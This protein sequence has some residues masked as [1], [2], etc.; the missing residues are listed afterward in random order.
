LEEEDGGEAES[1]SLSWAAEW[2][3]EGRGTRGASSSSSSTAVGWEGGWGFNDAEEMVW[4]TGLDATGVLDAAE[5]FE[6][7]AEKKEGGEGAAD[8]CRGEV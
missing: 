4:G 1:P 6:P 5:T 7:R 3:A 2:A 8:G